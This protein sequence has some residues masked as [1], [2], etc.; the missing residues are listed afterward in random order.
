MLCFRQSVVVV[1]LFYALPS[2]TVDLAQ[3]NIDIQA[4]LD[5]GTLSPSDPIFYYNGTSYLSQRDDLQLTIL[6]CETSCPHSR[7]EF[8]DDI[9]PRLLTWLIPI[10]LMIGNIHLP[11]I[12]F[13]HRVLIIF[14]HIGDPIDAMWSLL[15]K[16]EVWSRF[17]SMAQWNS[18]GRPD[19]SSNPGTQ[20]VIWCAIEEL[21][22]DMG[23]VVSLLREIHSES[24]HTLSRDDLNHILA[25]TA[26]ELVDSRTNEVLR[27][28][29]VIF[30]Y[31][32]SIIAAFVP[33]IGG[34][35][36][37]QPGG[38]IGTAMFLSFII[39]SV[40]LSNTLSGF[41]SRRTCL[42]ILER[43][44]RTVKERGHRDQHLF[45]KIKAR[46]STW[47]FHG[48]N[49]KA[50][51]D[52]YI[53]A[54]PWN[55]A[56]YCFRPN[57]KLVPSHTPGDRSPFILL[58][59]AALPVLASV[60]CAFAIIWIT[61]TIGLSCRN[62]WVL[63]LG[64]VFLVS[65]ILTW[66]FSLVA[67][68]KYHWYLTTAKDAMISL[69]VLTIVILSSTGLFNTCWCWSAVYSLGIHAHV[70][71]DPIDERKHYGLTLYPTLVGICLGLQ[72]FAYISMYL[73]M[74]PGAH[75]F[76]L[77]EDEKMAN[78]RTLGEDFMTLPPP[79]ISPSL[80]PSHRRRSSAASI[81]ERARSM[82]FG[83][84]SPIS[85]GALSPEWQAS[86]HPLLGSPRRGERS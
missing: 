39:N 72:L 59:L 60:S 44:N 85:S 34:T 69:S 36:S 41:S 31:L 3:C 65:P 62:L 71:L 38:R 70:I 63:S 58:I 32:W 1:L 57:K 56:V 67:S 27:A 20:A 82:S 80:G 52:D 73:I 19:A 75:V 11:R 61:P 14:H 81:G 16:A 7:D 33:S 18:D 29:L 15:T 66:V 84:P 77:S 24:G 8:Y 45:S 64:L 28:L 10:L 79:A 55:G 26:D 42:R 53:D 6:G 22:G 51:P 30:N 21:T 17:Y 35:S 12:G 40:M 68:G 48:K 54:Q 23:S 50:Q 37:S 13:K 49:K 76:R 25:E 5:N 74:R 4:R 83:E 86:E 2:A 9:G 43:Y 47:F 78:Y 46:T